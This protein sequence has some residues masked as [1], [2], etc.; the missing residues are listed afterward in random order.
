MS[1]LWAAHS[2]EAWNQRAKNHDLPMW[3][4]V[5]SL[6]FGHHRRN[7]H[8]NFAPGDL[9][10]ILAVLDE[11]TGELRPNANVSRSIKEAVGYGLLTPASQT[12]CL[13]VVAHE[14]WGGSYG[15][16]QAPCLVHDGF[17]AR[18]K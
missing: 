16:A 12:T 7:G 6:A 4:R 15:T 18:A 11:K 8:A 2:Q 14:V 3:L 10:K 17:A 13:V 9:K 1:V 5:A